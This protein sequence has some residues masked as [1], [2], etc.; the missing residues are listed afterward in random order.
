MGL[1]NIT[2]NIFI[3]R[4]TSIYRRANVIMFRQEDDMR[5]DW[6]ARTFNLTV[7]KTSMLVFHCLTRK[8]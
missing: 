7:Q 8:S 1:E 6:R 5:E 3:L 2:N 4:S